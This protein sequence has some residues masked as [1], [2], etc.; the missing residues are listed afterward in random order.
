MPSD[1]WKLLSAP[2]FS[3]LDTLTAVDDAI[4]C[5]AEIAERV[6]EI[7]LASFCHAQQ[8]GNEM[9][10]DNDSG[11]GDGDVNALP[12]WAKASVNDVEKARSTLRQLYR[13]WSAEGAEERN[14]SYGPILR[15]LDDEFSSIADRESS[16]DTSISNGTIHVS[17]A[18][19]D[20]SQI[21]VL[22]PGAG[23]G[24]LVFEICR[25]GYT[26]EG[27]EISYHQLLTSSLML[28]HTSST[29]QY[30]LYPW[31]TSFSNHVTR[32]DQLQKVMVPDVHPGTALHA[33]S[34]GQTT[35]A[36][37][38]MGMTAADF[39]VLYKGEEYK[40]YFDAVT[41]VFFIDTAPNLI[42][43]IE[44]VRN[45]LKRNG[46]WINLGP[47]LWH[48]ESRSE[49]LEKFRGGVQGKSNRADDVV[50][51]EGSENLGI[52]DPGSVE[53]SDDEVVKLVEHFGF[54]VQ[55]RERPEMGYI[56]NPKSMLQSIYRP[57]FWVAR[58]VLS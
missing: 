53:L 55:K 24:R 35:H 41:T 58:K 20:K 45:C 9:S 40:E 39:C 7:G 43:Y 46:V 38:R 21:R 13:D 29:E 8:T 56:Q 54:V 23:L 28:N 6:Y 48:F 49:G 11:A 34:E 26:V 52:G 27:N 51:S 10:D 25:A 32:Q 15:A 50:S 44:T 37:D 42:A 47:L 57:S 1:H 19:N 33:S 22:V 12:A 31:A 30:T 16:F 5:N 18:H 14:A 4:D 36:F 3:L 17:P 2:P